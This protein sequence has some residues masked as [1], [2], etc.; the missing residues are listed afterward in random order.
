MYN[1]V[2]GLNSVSMVLNLLEEQIL[3]CSGNFMWL[4]YRRFSIAISDLKMLTEPLDG[5]LYFRY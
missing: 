4:C 1:I 5:F 3:R 2:N